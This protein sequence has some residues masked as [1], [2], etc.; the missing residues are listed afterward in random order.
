M[1]DNCV[2]YLLKDDIIAVICGV[3]RVGERR[4]STIGIT[5]FRNLADFCNSKVFF[6][7]KMRSRTNVLKLM[8]Q[9]YVNDGNNSNNNNVDNDNN[10]KNKKDSSI[11]IDQTMYSFYNTNIV[12]EILILIEYIISATTSRSHIDE[13]R[14]I[15]QD[16]III[17][18]QQSIEEEEEQEEEQESNSNFNNNNDMIFLNNQEVLQM[19][20][21]ITKNADN[22]K[23]HVTKDVDYE[24][25]NKSRRKDG[26]AAANI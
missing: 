26:Y 25:A 16:T 6:A 20:Y 9:R 11:D 12:L 2:D 19:A 23:H 22:R 15:V 3:L 8:L 10:S 24:K 5:I 14:D 17:N 13:L 7:S 18:Q 21:K 1:N 4:F